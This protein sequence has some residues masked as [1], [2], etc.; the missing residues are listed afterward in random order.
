MKHNKLKDSRSLIHCSLFHSDRINSSGDIQI[1]LSP[2]H[3]NFRIFD[4]PIKKTTRNLEKEEEKKE[5]ELHFFF[6]PKGPMFVVK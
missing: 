1:L 6:N 4:P 2:K 5:K 3:V